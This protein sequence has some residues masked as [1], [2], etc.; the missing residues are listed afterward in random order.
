M[1]DYTDPAPVVAED[2][3]ESSRKG[4]P[5]D[6]NPMVSYWVDR[7]RFESRDWLQGA[8]RRCG[9]YKY[10][11]QVLLK[12]AALPIE[13]VYLPLIESGCMSLS[14]S[15]KDAV[16]HWQFIKG[17][18]VRYGLKVNEAIDERRDPLKSTMAAS[19]YIRDL[20]N[21]FQN[22]Y[23]TLAA[24]N[25]GEVRVLAAVMKG[26]TRDFWKLCEKNLLPRETQEYVPKFLAAIFLGENAQAYSLPSEDTFKTLPEIESVTLRGPFTITELSRK[27]GL[28]KEWVTRL[29]PQFIS[30]S[31]PA[32]VASIDAWFPKGFG[33]K[34]LL[35]LDGEFPVKRAQK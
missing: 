30:D 28:S 2:K 29:N 6:L 5:I 33:R 26:N 8:L 20:Y 11:Q 34:A 21:V 17:T 10:A 4:I 13:L 31:V 35:A 27:I 15:P 24:Y 25:L 18:A 9:V 32:N 12:R 7:F 23:L 3:F 16:G 19:H 1:V 14:R 22:W